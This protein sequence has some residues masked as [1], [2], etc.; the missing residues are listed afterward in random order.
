MRKISILISIVLISLLAISAVSAAD[1]VALTDDA[2][3]GAAD[4]IQAIDDAGANNDIDYDPDEII[5]GT[6]GDSGDLDEPTVSD[7]AAKSN[8]LGANPLGAGGSLSDLATAIENADDELILDG[9]YTYANRDS[10]NGITIDKDITIIGNGHTIDGNNRAAIFNIAQNATVVLKGIGFIHGTSNFGGAIYNLGHLTLEDCLFYNNTANKPLF[11]DGGQGG[12]VYNDESGVLDIIGGNFIDNSAARRGGAIYNLGEMTIDYAEFSN[13]EASGG[14]LATAYG[15][16]IYNVGDATIA[17]TSFTNNQTRG[18]LSHVGQGGAIYN[19]GSLDLIDSDFVNNAANRGIEFNG[20][21][22]AIYNTVNADAEITGT[23]FEQNYATRHGG[24]IYNAGILD[25]SDNS[26]TNNT[27]NGGFLPSSRGVGGAVYNDGLADIEDSTFEEN[28]ADDATAIF[29]ND[30]LTLAGNLLNEEEIAIHNTEGATIGGDLKV[31]IFDGE[32]QGTQD[33]RITLWGT[34]TDDMGNIIYDENFAFIIIDETIPYTYYDEEL[35]NPYFAAL[36][37]LSI[38]YTY[39]D[40]ETG[41]YSAPYTFAEP[42]N[43]IVY[44]DYPDAEIIDAMVYYNT[45]LI[46]LQALIDQAQ[47]GDTIDLK[48]DYYYFEE[49]DKS[50]KETGVIV[51]KNL[52]INGNTCIVNGQDECRIFKVEEGV[53]FVINELYF[54]HAFFDEN[55]GTIYSEG[56]LKV[57]NC[58]FIDNA[59][60]SGGAIHQSSTGSSHINDTFFWDNVAIDTGGAINF[61]CDNAMIENSYFDGNIANYGGA[62]YWNAN[63]AIF[64]NTTFES[65]EAKF[66]GGALFWYAGDA[67]I[68]MECT[69]LNNTA[70]AAGAFGFAGNNALIVESEFTSNSATG[71]S[72]AVGGGAIMYYGNEAIIG[73]SAFK[74]N[75]AEGNGG[76]IYFLLSEDSSIT[77]CTFEDNIA[78]IE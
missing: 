24:A 1:D 44:A 63:K 43:Y 14:L 47:D 69:F 8:S 12:A 75:T 52:T 6:T 71:E 77:G 30:D 22:G 32:N 29:N 67:A 27:A 39:Y 34:L 10:T 62:A 4:E 68:T 15:G 74:E 23:D 28:H 70:A 7:D 13:N 66:T 31:V 65:N 57:N 36:Q 16:A 5:A 11:G 61:Y 40:E 50:L 64:S 58:N 9:D 41:I 42:G 55:G 2:D 46:S 17:D 18:G 48:Y 73:N 35:V 54:T 33:G 78:L 53:K 76:A 20:D 37:G 21:G 26:F 51:N 60:F 49:F 45:T 3:L 25:A 38:P 19:D 59:A 56:D 72:A